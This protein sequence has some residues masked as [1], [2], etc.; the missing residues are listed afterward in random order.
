MADPRFRRLAGGA[1]AL[2]LHVVWCPKYRSRLLRKQVV[3][4][5]DDLLDETAGDDD[6]QIGACEVIPDHVPVFVR[7]HPTDSPAEGVDVG[8][9]SFAV[10]S[11]G[12]HIDDPRWGRKAAGKLEDAQQG[13]AQ[14]RS[15]LKGRAEEAGRAVIDVDPRHTS[16][17]CATCGH[18]HPGNH[19]GQAVFRC[20]SCGHE[21]HADVNTARNI[22]RAGLARPDAPAA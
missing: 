6:G 21:A 5:L 15:I 4:R 9:A 1:S 7:V 2:G 13:W 18:V 3:A 20:C 10:T 17:M 8:S 12:H 19:V 11:E 22:L 16:Q 14:F